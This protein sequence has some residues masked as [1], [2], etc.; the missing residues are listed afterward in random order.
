MVRYRK[1]NAGDIELITELYS[2]H[3]NSGESISDSIRQAWNNGDFSGYI[4]EKGGEVIGFFAIRSGIAFT[5]P[6]PELER[7]IADFSGDKK[8][9][10]CDALLILPGYRSEGIAR[11]LSQKSRRLLLKE[12]FEHFLVEIWIY[13][14]GQAPSRKVFEEMGSVVFSRKADGFYSELEKYGMGCPVCGEHCVCGALIE[15]IEL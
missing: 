4:A 5:Y 7:E 6:H 11:R 8:T 1:I 10:Y 13:P 15:V 9:G 14:D 12:G 3:L 2:V